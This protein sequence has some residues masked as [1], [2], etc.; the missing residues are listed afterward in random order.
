MNKGLESQQ[1][2]GGRGYGQDKLYN[3][4]PASCL[5]VSLTHK[6]SMNVLGNLARQLLAS[7]SGHSQLFNVVYKSWSHYQTP[8]SVRGKSGHYVVIPWLC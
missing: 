8:P 3:I 7:S 4:E 1:E 5:I 2:K 6:K